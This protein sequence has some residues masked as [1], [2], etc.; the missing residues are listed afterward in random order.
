[1]YYDNKGGGKNI[2]M[3]LLV[4][5]MGRSYSNISYNSDTKN[6]NIDLIVVM[7]LNEIVQY[8]QV[9]FQGLRWKISQYAHRNRPK[10]KSLL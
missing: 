10:C 7:T 1:M 9:I 2:M 3:R 8:T 6:N 5:I 4:I